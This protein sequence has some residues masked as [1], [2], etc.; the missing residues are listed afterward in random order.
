LP[1]MAK[2]LNSLIML[3]LLVLP[4]LGRMARRM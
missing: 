2:A 4:W 3:M 1:R